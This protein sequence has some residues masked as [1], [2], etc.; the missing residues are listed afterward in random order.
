MRDLVSIV[1]VITRLAMGI[2]ETYSAL[3]V[4]GPA[5]VQPEVLPRAVGH[6][7]ATPAVGQLVGN[8]IDIL[9]V[10]GDNTGGSE[11]EDGVLHATVGKARRQD[12]NIILAPDV[13]IDDFLHD[14]STPHSSSQGDLL[15]I[16]ETYLDRIDKVLGIV[17]KLPLALIQ[18]IRAGGNHTAR[19]N[20]CLGDITGQYPVN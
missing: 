8:H 3:Q 18:L 20:G 19:A 11:S 14:V 7:I 12:Q 5:L 1:V 2:S 10:F 17:L 6:Q 15:L 16:D 4:N 9:A 13:R